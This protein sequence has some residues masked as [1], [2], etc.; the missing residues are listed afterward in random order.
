[1]SSYL[2]RSFNVSNNNPIDSSLQQLNVNRANLGGD[3][4]ESDDYK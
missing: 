1:M 3:Y 2:A 4:D